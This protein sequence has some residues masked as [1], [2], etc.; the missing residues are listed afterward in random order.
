MEIWGGTSRGFGSRFWFPQIALRSYFPVGVGLG[1]SVEDMTE[2]AGEEATELELKERAMRVGGGMAPGL[3]V[4]TEGD[5]PG[6][7]LGLTGGLYEG[8]SSS[9]SSQSSSSSSPSSSSSGYLGVGIGEGAGEAGGL[10]DVGRR[11]WVDWSEGWE[12]VVGLTVGFTIGVGFTTGVG[13]P[14]FGLPTVGQCSIVLVLVTVLCPTSV[15]FV[16]KTVTYE[17]TVLGGLP[18]DDWRLLK[19]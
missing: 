10:T 18:G 14:W 15:V 5:G 8:S 1:A 16:L 9:S 4:E 3:V 11:V 7:T 12:V 13:F 2:V 17:I 6:L 19:V